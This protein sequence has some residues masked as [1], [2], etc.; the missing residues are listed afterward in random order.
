MDAKQA[1]GVR[2]GL[3]TTLTFSGVPD[4]RF[5]GEVLH[6][7]T[8]QIPGPVGLGKQPGYVAI[9][10]FKN[11][12]E[13]VQPNMTATVSIKLGSVKDVPAVPSEAVDLDPTG[14]PVVKALRNGQWKPVVVQL[15]LSD[16]QYTQIKSGLKKGETVQVTPKLRL[17]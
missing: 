14:R 11:E 5:P 9:L 7:T 6:L 13:Q 16:G 17:P 10:S 12:Q 4:K 8:T 3:P 2:P 15:G 1:A